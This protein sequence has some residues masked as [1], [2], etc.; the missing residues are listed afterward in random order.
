MAIA[1]REAE[2]AA[3]VSDSDLG[4][5]KNERITAI[6]AEI[7]ALKEK[8]A[9]LEKAW[10]SEQAIVEEIRGLR[11]SLAK[12][13]DGDDVEG[14]RGRTARANSNRWKASI[15][16]ERMIYAHMSTSSPMVASVVSD[17]T[18]IPVGRMVRDE[19]ETVLKLAGNSQ[20]PR[21]RSIA[22]LGDDCQT[23]RNQPRQAG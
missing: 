18:G 12:P 3:L 5:D 20:S 9:G 17:W 22:W 19:I 13:N 4:V 10:A 15:P 21:G 8:L 2:R 23:H 11:E 1:A 16:E 14:K 7:A 6:D